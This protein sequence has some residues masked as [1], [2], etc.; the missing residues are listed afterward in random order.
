MKGHSWHATN[1]AD[2]LRDMAEQVK[3]N[4]P[5]VRAAH[6]GVLMWLIQIQTPAS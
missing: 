1:F 4:T 2:M 6:G 3:R 5:P